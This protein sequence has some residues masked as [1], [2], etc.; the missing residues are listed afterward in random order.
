MGMCL[1]S[2]CGAPPAGSPEAG[3][4][5]AAPLDYLKEE[6]LPA[7]SA[8]AQPMESGTHK[9][10]PQAIPLPRPSKN[11]VKEDQTP[12]KMDWGP[13]ISLDEIVT[14]AQ[15]GRIR[16]IQW[17]VMPNIL[18]IETPDGRVFHLRNENRGVDL[19]NTLIESGVQ[20]GKGGV[21][22]RHVF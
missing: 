3:E 5:K 8:P 14:M 10:E 6:R 19:R 13:E 22:F 1:L 12:Q 21:I 18:R 2:A 17:H 9:I 11:E 7:I 4:T 16:E 20:V 15:S